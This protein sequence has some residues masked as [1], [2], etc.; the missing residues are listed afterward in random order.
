MAAY[1]ESESRKHWEEGAGER[2]RRQ[3]SMCMCRGLPGHHVH[4][5]LGQGG[6]KETGRCDRGG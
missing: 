6:E 4:L 2:K 3:H 5:F 1:L